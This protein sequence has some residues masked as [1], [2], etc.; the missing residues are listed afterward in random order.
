M[1]GVRNTFCTLVTSG[2]GG[3]SKP[4]KN[5]ISGCMPAEMRSVERSSARGISDA[6]GRKTWPF[7]SWNSR[8]PARSSAVVRTPTILGV[9]RLLLGG[10]LLADLFQRSPDQPRD[11]HLRDPDLLRDLRLRQPLEEPQVQDPA[12]A[13]VE[14]PEARGEHGAVLR[15]LVLMLLGAERLERVE[16]PVLVVAR[17]GGQRERAVRATALERLE[18]LFVGDARGLGEL[19]DR[20]RAAVLHGELLDQPRELDVQLLQAARHAYRPAAVA[21]MALDLADDVR[22]RIGRELDAA[23]DVETV[24][25]LDQADR[26]DLDEVLELLAA[27]GVAAGEGAHERHVLLD[28]LRAG[29]EVAL[30]VVAA[31]EDLVARAAHAAPFCRSRLFDTSS[32]SPSSS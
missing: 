12:L 21:E 9:S 14:H 10:D 28:Q 32:H 3:S 8:K 19:G 5:G 15:D 31:E 17:P 27:I 29:R 4:R 24:D 18:H 11:V 16:L 2:A 30:L 1:S 20:R 22:R 25:R 23:V 6:E 7:D 26:A 13:L